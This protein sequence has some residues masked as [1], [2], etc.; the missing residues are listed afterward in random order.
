MLFDAVRPNAAWATQPPPR[1]ADSRVEMTVQPGDAAPVTQAGT[2]GRRSTSKVV[3][4]REVRSNIEIDLDEGRRYVLGK[5][6]ACDIVLQDPCVSRVH[7]V[8]E[9]H[10]PALFVRDSGSRNGTFVNDRR[11]ECGE[12]TPGTVLGLGLTQLVALGPAGRA[13]TG[14]ERLVG[15]DPALRAAIEVGRRAAQTEC[16]VLIVGETGTGK[17]VMAQAIHESSRRAAGPFVALNCGAIPRELIGSELFGH[18]RGAFTGATGERDGVFLQA[19]G[20][21]LFLDELGELPLE[22]QPHLLRAL[23]TRQVRR[24]GGF[25]ERSFDA[26]MIAATNRDSQLG[27][28]GGALRVDL[29]HRLATVIIRM[30]ALRARVADI[31]ALCAVFLEEQ[32]REHGPRRLSPSARRALREHHWPGNVRELRQAIVRAVAFSTDIIDADHL[33]PLASRQPLDPLLAPIGPSLVP[34]PGGQALLSYDLMVRDAMIEALGRHGT[35]RA[36]AESLGM[37]KSTFADR[38]RRLQIPLPRRPCRP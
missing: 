15:H 37:A 31:E 33:F 12:L 27:S 16:S 30:P 13:R 29:F 38:A 8:L 24:V 36:A 5:G 22:Q 6:E 2:S 34:P 4:L 11:V 14:F 28:A 26:R 7:C 9:R 18:E 17:D 32:A 25:G 20:G 1:V 3:G 23:E 35:M 19:T 10:G 21:T